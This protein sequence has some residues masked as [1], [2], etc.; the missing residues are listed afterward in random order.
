MFCQSEVNRHLI[1]SSEQLIGKAMT[2]QV[3]QCHLLP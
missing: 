1:G 3:A 2:S